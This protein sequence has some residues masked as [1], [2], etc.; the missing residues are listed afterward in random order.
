MNLAFTC[1]QVNKV[2]K[3]KRSQAKE[4]ALHAKYNLS[5]WRQIL[6]FYYLVECA[7]TPKL[8]IL[9]PQKGLEFSRGVMC[10]GRPKM[11]KCMKLDWNFHRGG[12]V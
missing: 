5:E 4:D 9:P 1:L 8:S 11:L 6:I 7:L 12:E 3:F 2:E 10:S